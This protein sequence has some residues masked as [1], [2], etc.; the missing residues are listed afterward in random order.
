MIVPKSIHN[1]LGHLLNAYI[2][3][4]VGTILS[5]AYA[6]TRTHSICACVLTYA[7]LAGQTERWWMDGVAKL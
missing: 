5:L 1:E 3:W 2:Q 4:C 7:Y 6:Q